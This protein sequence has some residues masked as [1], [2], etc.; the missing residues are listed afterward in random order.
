MRESWQESRSKKQNVMKIDEDQREW[1]T[2]SELEK[3]LWIVTLS[4]SEEEGKYDIIIVVSHM[5]TMV[6]HQP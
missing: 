3:Q 4:L 5:I 6:R 2:I 1:W